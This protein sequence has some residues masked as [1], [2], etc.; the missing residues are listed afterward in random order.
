[1]APFKDARTA[2]LFIKLGLVSSARIVA[3]ST[4]EQEPAPHE[5]HRFD[6]TL[7]DGR[8][9]RVRVS[10]ITPEREPV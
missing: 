9:Y 3:T 1:M 10:D 6:M 4:L 7:G 2:A 8:V 5:V